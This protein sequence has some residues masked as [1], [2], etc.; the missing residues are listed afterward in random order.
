[1]QRNNK[2][3]PLP[4][5]TLMSALYRLEARLVDTN[6]WI[7]IGQ[8]SPRWLRSYVLPAWQYNPTIDGLRITA[9]LSDGRKL[10]LS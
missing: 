7:D 5:N 6:T 3:A 8:G 2:Q 4:P 1:M 10:V 9:R